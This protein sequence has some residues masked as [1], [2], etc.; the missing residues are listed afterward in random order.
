MLN[1]A[2]FSSAFKNFYFNWRIIA[3]QYCVGFCHKSTRLCLLNLFFSFLSHSPSLSPQSLCFLNVILHDCETPSASR[4]GSRVPTIS[5][6]LD[7]TFPEVQRL[8]LH[9][10][11]QGAWF[12]SVV[13]ELRFRM[14][15]R[16]AKNK[17]R[18]N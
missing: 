3:V 4:P 1:K 5:L 6:A 18:K 11:M 14:Q 8:R 9:S 13:W 7:G 2:F 12:Q 17:Q 10:P 16:A 15:W